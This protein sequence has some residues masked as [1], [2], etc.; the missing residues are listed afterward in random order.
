MDAQP[1]PASELRF[2]P[3]KN[4]PAHEGAACP[5]CVVLV[6]ERT[7]YLVPTGD[8]DGVVHSVFTRAC[9]IACGGDLLLTLAGPELGDGPTTLRLGRGAPVDFRHLFCPGDRLRCRDR[10]AH[11]RGVALQFAGTTVWR[12]APLRPF[13]SAAQI[14]VNLEL[15]NLALARRRRTHSS[16]VDREGGPVLAGLGQA[17]RKLDIERASPHLGRLIGWGEGLTPAGDDVLVGCCAALDALAGGSGRRRAFVAG[18]GA[19]IA[20]ATHRT[21]PVAAHYLR[22]AARGH[23]NADVMHLRDALLCVQDAAFLEVALGAALAAGATSGA[24]MVTGM[25]AGIA[26]WRI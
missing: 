12:P 15:A 14:A 20:A 23:F 1:A 3:S 25:I 17:C 19:V 8:F 21:T 18:F 6:A 24:D 9:N 4:R 7:G 2:A 22:L 16:A 11:A 13:A 10:V 26:A 5:P